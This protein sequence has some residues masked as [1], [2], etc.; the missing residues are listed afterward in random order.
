LKLIILYSELAL[1]LRSHP[2]RVAHHL[3]N[4]GHG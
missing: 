1:P 2:I 4:I 3:L